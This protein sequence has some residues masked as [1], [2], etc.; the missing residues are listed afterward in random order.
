MQSWDEARYQHSEVGAICWPVAKSTIP[1]AHTEIIQIKMHS[2]AQRRSLR[3]AKSEGVYRVAPQNE[4]PCVDDGRTC[5][6]PNAASRTVPRSANRMATMAIGHWQRCR[7]EQAPARM[8]AARASPLGPNELKK[9]TLQD[10]LSSRRH[11][12]NAFQA[13]LRLRVGSSPRQQRHTLSVWI[14]G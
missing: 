10:G 3:D 13:G 2:A 7:R 11:A 14:V 9:R 4:T 6:S 12:R 8:A 1:R 5:T